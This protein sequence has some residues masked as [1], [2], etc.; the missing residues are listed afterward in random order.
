MPDDP[1]RQRAKKPPLQ[2]RLRTLLG[3]TTALALLFA[4]LEWL[5]VP[6]LASFLVLVLLAVSVLA[7]LALVIVIAAS[8]A[9][10][11]DDRE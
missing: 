5:G 2:F 3:V 4:T 10:D 1:G 7:A 9:G 8:V 11:E 6:P